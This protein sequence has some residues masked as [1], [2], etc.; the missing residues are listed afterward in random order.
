M[1]V[2]LLWSWDYFISKKRHNYRF[3]LEKTRPVFSQ[4]IA[5]T[6]ISRLRY[7]TQADQKTRELQVYGSGKFYPNWTFWNR[8][9][10]TLLQG[11]G[12]KL[13]GMVGIYFK[14]TVLI[15]IQF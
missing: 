14:A 11:E 8:L 3:S 15:A 7:Q 10:V 1:S 6:P 5:F 2:F 4:H 13:F 9:E 12:S